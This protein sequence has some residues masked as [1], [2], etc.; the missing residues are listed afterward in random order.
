MDYTLAKSI[1]EK[2]R[3]WPDFKLY[4]AKIV[5]HL[6]AD[7]LENF[8]SLDQFWEAYQMFYVP[9]DDG[10]FENL[11]YPHEVIYG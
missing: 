2:V 1:I 3:T 8:P 9:D 10:A 5:D 4:E 7:T 6:K 11:E